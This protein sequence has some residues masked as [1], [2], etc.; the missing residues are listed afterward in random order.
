MKLTKETHAQE[1]AEFCGIFGNPRRIRIIWALTNRELTVGEIAK[2]IE[3]SMQNTSQH[4]R[5]MRN[6][7]VLKS[8]RDGREI[9]YRV[10]DTSLIQ[11]CPMLVKKI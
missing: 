3:A 10:A 2:E 4:L 11:N 8:R 5:L 6:K 9:Y 1:Q 7:G